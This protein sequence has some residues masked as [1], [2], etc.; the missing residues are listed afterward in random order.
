MTATP[1]RHAPCEHLHAFHDGEL[2]AAAATAF[3]QHLA[4]CAACRN[5]L[6]ELRAVRRAVAE[7]SRAVPSEA[8]ITA[9]QR[10]RRHAQERQV[11]RL[12]SWMTAAAAALLLAASASL[13][14]TGSTAAAVPAPEWEVRM[15]ASATPAA[16]D[17][18]DDAAL[19]A[20]WLA[21]DLAAGREGRQLQ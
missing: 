19:L 10:G 14:W 4:T 18:A 20:R 7:A 16:E 6:D 13:V 9:W 21:A 2:A 8:Q 3:E 5:G 15:L 1:D 12:A 11:L 17:P